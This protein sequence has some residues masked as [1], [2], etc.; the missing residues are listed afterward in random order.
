MRAAGLHHVGR[1]GLVDPRGG[2]TG[3]FQT[4]AGRLDAA[5]RT[6][7]ARLLVVDPVSRRSEF[8]RLKDVA[9]AASLGKFKERLALLAD[10]KAIGPTG[11][12]LEGVPPG[13]VTHFAGEARV[14]DAADMRKVTEDKR[15]TLMV[16][17]VHTAATGVL[18]DV[19]T[20]F[21]KRMGA[22][23]KKGRD[24][25]ESLHE[26]HRAESE[27]LLGVFGD[28][29]SVVR[30]AMTP[31]ETPADVGDAVAVGEPVPV[32]AAPSTVQEMAER[33]GRLVLKTLEQSGGLNALASAHEAVSAHHGNNY[34]PLLDQQY[35]SHRS[36]LAM[37]PR[38]V[39]RAVVASARHSLRNEDDH[40]SPMCPAR[41]LGL[42]SR[43]AE[44]SRRSERS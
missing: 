2:D 15:L 10:I 28:V 25:L 6:R 18:D 38:P 32:V 41:V 7:L 21:C 22:I 31:A 12:W 9:K 16:S 26:A 42:S 20:M 11:W 27:R 40:E 43:D 30:E 24:H 44:S 5:A 19:V 34:L 29:L 37:L 3:F 8:D 36:A 23:H 35:R 14:T 39:V 4:V 1:D 17:L 33:A 13:K